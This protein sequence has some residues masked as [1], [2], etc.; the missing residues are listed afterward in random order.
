MQ[1]VAPARAL[2]DQA[3]ER[4]ERLPPDHPLKRQD[5]VKLRRLLAEA[6]FRELRSLRREVAEESERD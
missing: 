6:A 4:L 5:P 1:E 2:V 3:L